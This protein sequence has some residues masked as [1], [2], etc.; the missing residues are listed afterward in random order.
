MINFIQM[1]EHTKNQHYVPQF[2]LKK[3]SS[4]GNKFIWALDKKEVQ[5]QN[6]KIKERP[7]KKVASEAF[8]Y[9]K[10]ENSRIGS[11]E[12]L[13]QKIEDSAA[14]VIAKI[15]DSKN[16]QNLD[17]EEREIISLFVILQI[18]RT[19]GQQI[20]I[21]G[22]LDSFSEEIK[23]KTGVNIEKMDSKKMWFS[24]LEELSLFYNIIN[25]KVWHLAECN[26]SFYTSDNPVTLQNTTDKSD[27]RGTLGLDSFGIEIY[28]PLSPSLTLCFFCE[29]VFKKSGYEG[30]YIDNTISRPEN[31]EN[32]NSLQVAF[33]ERFIFSHKNDFDFAQKIL[34]NTP[35]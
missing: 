35:L 22:M 20:L 14:P 29:K 21:K 12:Y 26:E 30:R 27:I 9:D 25:N 18:L 1:N 2:Y 5:N 17:E 32:L 24:L 3:F 8:F 7:I 10:I 19:K 15:I 34:K 11:Y 33:S 4:K 13:L 31:I 28:F 16:I 23:S 6:N